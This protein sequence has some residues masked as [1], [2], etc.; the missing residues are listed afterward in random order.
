MKKKI[1]ILNQNIDE[2]SAM[3]QLFAK[4]GCEVI[5]ATSW[6]TA[7]KLITNIDIDYMVLDARN[8]EFKEAFQNTGSSARR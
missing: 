8:R 7:L 4:E 5:T 6:E 1:L 2:L 3:R